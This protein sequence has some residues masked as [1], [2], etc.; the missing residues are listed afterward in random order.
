VINIGAYAQC[1]MTNYTKYQ[2]YLKIWARRRKIE[3][4]LNMIGEKLKKYI[5]W[6]A[7]KH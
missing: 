1:K 7:E 6:I 2:E 3:R 4:E 5:S